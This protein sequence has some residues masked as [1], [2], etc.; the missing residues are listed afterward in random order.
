MKKQMTIA[1]LV[2]LMA[3]GAAMSQGPG[4]N[5]KRAPHDYER[6]HSKER[7][8]QWHAERF[9]RMDTD[10]DGRLTVDELYQGLQRERAERLHK[11]LDTDG[12]GFVSPDELAAMQNKRFMRKGVKRHF[13]K[14]DIEKRRHMRHKPFGRP[15]ATQ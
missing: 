10:G 1:A 3:S 5:H 4:A 11:W 13:D 8:K 9:A 12:D 6:I 14:G 2:L 7:M 15:N